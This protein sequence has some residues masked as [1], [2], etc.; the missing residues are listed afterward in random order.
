[1]WSGSCALTIFCTRSG[2]T[3]DMASLTLPES[4]SASPPARPVADPAAVERPHGRVGEPGLV[5][6]GPGP[7]LHRQLLESVGGARGRDLALV[8][9][10]AGPVLGGLEDHG[11]GQV[12]HLLQ[13]AVAVGV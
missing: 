10:P 2:T 1:M 13:R 7:V 5:P 6:G 11:G 9:L 4:T 8:A 12:G 3:W